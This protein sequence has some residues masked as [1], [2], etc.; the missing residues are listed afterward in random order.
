MKQKSKKRASHGALS[1]FGYAFCILWKEHRIYAVGIVL[2][3]L[4]LPAGWTIS[5]FINKYAM[6]AITVPG[7]RARNLCILAIL[8]LFRCLTELLNS[9]YSLY[10]RYYGDTRGNWLFIRKLFQKRLTMDY[11]NMELTSTGDKFQKALGGCSAS[12][13]EN[14]LRTTCAHLFQVIIYSAVLAGLSPAMILVSGAPALLCFLINYHVY[15][16]QRRNMD[17]WTGL[18]RQLAYVSSAASD[19]SCAKDVRLYHM[20]VWLRHKFESVLEKRLC[21]CRRYDKRFTLW[22][23]VMQCISVTSMI[24][25]YGITIYMVSYGQIGAGDFV[26]YFSSIQRY[27]QAIWELGWDL[28]HFRGLRDQIDYYRDYLELPD[29]FNHGE[30]IPLPRGECEL[31]LRHVS[32][33]YPNAGQPTI[34]DISFKLH[35]G[36]RLAL[37]GL[38]GAGKTTLIKL[39]C[40]LY[41]VTEG[42]ILLN[43]QDIRKYNREEYYTLFSTVF[44]D[45]DILPVTIAQNITQQFEASP[46]QAGVWDA[47]KKAGLY[48][49]VQSLPAKENTLLAKSVYDEATDFSGGETQKLALAKALYKNAPLL[50]LDEPTAAL[51]A[52]SEQ[53]MYLQYAA[54]SRG[55]ASVFISHRLAS[56][57]FCDNIILIEDGRIAEHGTHAELMDK[58]EKYAE[59][60]ELQSAYYREKVCPA[61]NCGMEYRAPV[62]E[63]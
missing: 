30:G 58:G 57:R 54:F 24:A 12:A 20:P 34:K 37:V 32:Y 21:W 3:A 48:D 11:Q 47:L 49:K 31:E 41:D 6:E 36:E 19:F 8:L 27:A 2:M 61:E 43:G 62:N 35:K 4:T 44:Q 63:F 52:I 14:T 26:L 28:S 38:N 33:T 13:V 22:Q 46:G 45:F 5:P 18:D 51:D 55:R 15:G 59:L 42:E 1:N 25:S 39:M 23:I 40:G 10:N 56:T 16:W 53:E 60:F 7:Q 17:N 50:L 9:Q 29:K